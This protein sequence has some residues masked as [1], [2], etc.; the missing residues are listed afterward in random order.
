MTLDAGLAAHWR[1]ENDLRDSSGHGHDGRAEG[2]SVLFS[3]GAVFDGTSGYVTM[4]D[5]PAL[6]LG[7]GDF[8]LAAQVYADAEDDGFSGDILSKYDPAAR[9]GVNLCCQTFRGVT[10]AQPNYRNLFFG[11][12]D[13]GPLSSWADCGRPGD[14]HM[15]WA[16]CVFKGSLY[17]ATFEAGKDQTGHVYRYEG[18]AAWTDCGRPHPSNAITSLAVYKGALYASASHYRSAGS[19]MS[20]SENTFAGGQ[21]FRYEGGTQ[22]TDCGKLGASEAIGGMAVYRGDLYA[23]SMYAPPGLFRYEGGTAWAECG[24]PGGRIEA[25]T[26]FQG[27]LHGSG[28][29]EGRSGMY[30]YEGGS[31]W[32]DCG[33]PA[34]TTQTYSFMMYQDRLYAGVWPGG[35]V[36]RHGGEQSW[37]DTGRLGDELEVMGMMLYNGKLYAGTLPLAQ[38]YRYDGDDAWTNTGQLDT[39]PD[40][41]YRR[42]WSMAVFQGKLFCGTL[43]SGHVFAL[44]AGRGVSHDDE[45]APGWRHLAAVRKAG[46]LRLYVDGKAVAASAAGVGPALDIN[47]GAPLTIGYGPQGRFGG[48]VRDVRLYHRPLSPAEVA[49]LSSAQE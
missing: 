1:L 15:V 32:T 30:R 46:V 4:P 35:K 14:C 10:S 47:T 22:W 33:T 7:T 42:A 9:K 3:D 5:D 21:V 29:D 8:T 6:D 11:V 12:D 48:R 37:E 43:P 26:V 18:G 28:W 39:T 17:A 49:A 45:L 24:H 31:Q 40:V 2:G 38:V 41:K 27:R 34:N 36:F 44:E 13:G 16:L 19:A 20:E 25:L 23:S